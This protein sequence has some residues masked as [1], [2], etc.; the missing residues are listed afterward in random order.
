[1]KWFLPTLLLV[2]ALSGCVAQ[3]G[4]EPQSRPADAPLPATLQMCGVVVDDRIHPAVGATVT[5]DD[6]RSTTTDGTGAFCIDVEDRRYIVHV[7]AEWGNTTTTWSPDEGELTITIQRE[8]APEPTLQQ[9][10]FEGFLQ[11]AAEGL[12]IS[13]SCDTILRFANDGVETQGGGRPLPEPLEAS[14]EFD[15]IIDPA[16]VALDIDVAFD[17][18]P[19]LDGLRLVLRGAEAGDDLTTYDQYG[20][21][22]APESFSIRVEPNGTY[23]YGDAPIPVGQDLFEAEVLPHSHA[24]HAV[25]DPDETNCFLGAGAAIDVAFQLVITAHLNGIVE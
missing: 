10:Q 19:G 1:M 11:C 3:E 15:F 24:Y 7:H 17:A 12:I 5:L 18:H 6:N 2:A 8:R 20:R 4:S 16:W 23:P 14:N 9:Y 25:C 13:G 22:H 21:W